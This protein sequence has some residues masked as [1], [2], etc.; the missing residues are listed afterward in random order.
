MAIHRE[1][2]RLHDED[3]GA[4]DIFENLKINFPIAEAVQLRLAQRHVEV[5]ADR[6]C[7]RKVGGAREDFETLVVHSGSLRSPLG[8]DSKFG[9]LGAA[10]A[11]L[12]VG[13]YKGLFKAPASKGGRYK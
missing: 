3:I 12:K 13:Q 8:G 6:L 2:T 9:L 5:L 7:Q 11:D 1:R 4:A 10:V